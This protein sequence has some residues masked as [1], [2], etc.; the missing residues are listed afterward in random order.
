MRFSQRCLANRLGSSPQGE[1]LPDVRGPRCASVIL[2]HRRSFADVALNRRR[3]G[4]RAAGLGGQAGLG[5]R[6]AH[7]HGV[8]A[9]AERCR[10]DARVRFDALPR[11]ATRSARSWP[12][13]S[14][15]RPPPCRR[16]VLPSAICASCSGGV[17]GR[18]A[19]LRADP[20][21]AGRQAGGRPTGEPCQAQHRVRARRTGGGGA[22]PDRHDRLRHCA[23]VG[24]LDGQDRP[25]LPRHL[26]PGAG[27]L[28]PRR[29]RRPAPPRVAGCRS[30][31]SRAAS[32]P[33]ST[34]N[35]SSPAPAAGCGSLPDNRAAHD[36]DTPGYGVACS[37]RTQPSRFA[38][39]E[40]SV[41]WTVSGISGRSL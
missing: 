22:D 31:R 27:R 5:R 25:A 34:G 10:V 40:V 19:E 23:G 35:C 41:P 33:S 2:C 28:P 17:R 4:A 30:P 13:R 24:R 39:N 36:V 37:A 38:D 8:L 7:P 11:S 16:P 29:A 14:W 12:A 9:A 26:V 15:P 6:W 1:R 18:G 32:R 20:A 21:R 3:R